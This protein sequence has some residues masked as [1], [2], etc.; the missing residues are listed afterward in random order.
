MVIEQQ[1]KNGKDTIFVQL[2]PKR[3]LRSEVEKE[4]RIS[5]RLSG[6]SQH[7]L[8]NINNGIDSNSLGKGNRDSIGTTDSTASEDDLPPPLPVKTREADYCNLPEELSANYCGTGSINSLN[9]SLGQWSKSKLPTPTDD[10]DVQTK[11]PTPPPKPKR[12]PYSLNKLMLSSDID[13][14]SQDPS[15]T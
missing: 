14:F 1:E 2:T 4:R 10:L 8:R 12:P 15:V 7:Y 6:Q 3:P 13:K 9:R 11:P 5:N